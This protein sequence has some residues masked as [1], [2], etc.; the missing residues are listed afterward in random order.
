MPTP[1]IMPK[2]EMAQETGTV[3]EWLK[4]EGDHVEKGDPI[5]IVGTDKVEMEVEAPATGTLVGI[6]AQPNDVIPIGQVIAY[7]VAPGETWTP[8]GVEAKSATSA[9]AATEETER[10]VRITPVAKRLAREHGLDVSR[11]QGTGPGGRITRE[12][13]EAAL[14]GREEK[15][16]PSGKV[17]AVPAARRLAR[18]LGVDLRTVKGTGPGGRI[19]SQDVRRAA[20]QARPT[21]VAPPPAVG[22]IRVRERRPLTNIQR[23]MAARMVESVHNAPQFTITMHVDMTRSL[24]TVEEVRERVEGVRMTMTAWLVYVLSRVLPHHPLINSSLQDEEVVLWED[25][26]IGVAVAVED[27]LIVP[28][29]HRAQEMGLQQIAERLQD[30]A[31][32]ARAGTLRLEDISDGTFT[33]SNLGMFGVDHFTAIVNPPQ[34]AILAV[35]RIRKEPVVMDEETWHVRPM[36]TMTLTSD[37]RVIDGATAARFLKEVREV[38]EHPGALFL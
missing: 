38:L 34:S 19:Q 18:E 2:Y 27:G 15:P 37:H 31:T 3:I 36:M 35:G 16:A 7:I 9:T 17:R 11:L 8:T 33:L 29:V 13:V 22:G 30:V 1:V 23:V 14:A 25:V 20:A 21:E 12:D 10:G 5:L 6:R 26:N 28:V 4:K 24:Q 32:R